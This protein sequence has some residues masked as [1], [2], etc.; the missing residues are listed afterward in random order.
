VRRVTSHFRAAFNERLSD[1][2]W[3]DLVEALE[4]QSEEFRLIW[5]E[6]TVLRPPDWRKVM[7]HPEPPGQE[8][9]C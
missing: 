1:R 2:S 8:N 5:R 9:L 4:R 3:T 7:N 6:C